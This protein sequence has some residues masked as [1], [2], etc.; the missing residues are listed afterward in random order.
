MAMA[1]FHWEA[2][3]LQPSWLSVAPDDLR[4]RLKTL[5]RGAGRSQEKQAHRMIAAP[6]WPVDAKDAEARVRSVIGYLYR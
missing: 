1:K 5:L 2:G 4:R 6:P 3:D